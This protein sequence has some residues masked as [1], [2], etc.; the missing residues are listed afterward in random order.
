MR[1][2]IQR[3]NS[4]ALAWIVSGGVWF[5]LGTTWGLFSA[6]HLIAPELFDNIGWLVFGR[7]RPVHVNTVIFGFV[8]P[9]LIGA[10][11]HYVP[12]MLKTKLWSE[13]LGWLAWLAWN[14][15]VVSGFVFLPQGVTQGREYTEYIFP[16]DVCVMIAL[17]LLIVNF[18]M[19]IATRREPLLY[20]SVWYVV[21]MA[22]WTAGVYPIG[23]VMWQP[24]TG[25]LPGVL[26]SIF[27]WFYGHNLVGLLLTR[28][29][30]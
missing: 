19:T 3:P 9:T 18:V 1:K 29:W 4:A 27:L 8:T 23:N 15:A 22:V 6:A 25:A 7:T 14:G 11:L 2:I 5:A 17:V 10:A 30:P 20:V 13:P 16:A 12:A 28:L 24:A 21:G 26:D